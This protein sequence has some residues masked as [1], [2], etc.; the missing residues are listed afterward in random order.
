MLNRHEQPA[1]WPVNGRRR[2]PNACRQAL[3]TLLPAVVMMMAGLTAS[4]ENASATGEPATGSAEPVNVISL[5]PDRDGDRITGEWTLF[6]TP[7]TLDVEAA[8]QSIR[9]E[10]RTGSLDY[11]LT[12]SFY[13]LGAEMENPGGR[14]RWILEIKNPHIRYVELYV[15]PGDEATWTR[16]ER[17][18]HGTRFDSRSIRHNYYALPLAFNGPERMQ[19]LIMLDNV[20]ASINYPATVWREASFVEYQQRQYLLNG[21]Y[22]GG[23][24]L[25]IMA[26]AAAFLLFGNSLYWWFVLHVFLTGL[27]VFADLGYAFQYLYPWSDSLNIYIRIYLSLLWA[28]VFC[29]FSQRYF[30]TRVHAPVM[31]RLLHAGMIAAAATML[32]H[33][34]IEAFYRPLITPYLVLLFGVLLAVMLITLATGLS[35]HRKTYHASMLYLLAFSFL[36][37][38]GALTVI[39]EFGAMIELP[40]R[41]S[42]LQLG[43]GLQVLVLTFGITWIMKKRSDRQSAMKSRIGRLKAQTLQSHIQGMEEERRRIAMN[44]HDAIGNRMGRLKRMMDEKGTSTEAFREEISQLAREVRSISHELSPPGLQTAGLE[45]QVRNLVRET[46]EQSTVRYRL[47]CLDVPA[48][49]PKPAALQVYRVIQEAVNNIEKHSRASTADIQLIGYGDE[50]VITIEDDGVG[51]PEDEHN[52]E[53]MGLRNMRERIAHLGGT[54]ELASQPGRG[55]QCMMVIP[56]KG[57]P[58]EQMSKEAGKPVNP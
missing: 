8:W 56:L 36:L 11:G 26:S 21:L 1:G 33:P 39:E 42:T 10:G 24:I 51:L 45:Q 57:S 30:T 29:R 49:L 52:R 28:L 55:V 6:T 13:W 22:F 37:V 31:H 44:L 43:S 4:P 35:M 40:V 41:F 46:D 3:R 5:T 58:G 48:D 12:R 19:V 7:D 27:Y 17:T 34:P 16:V 14:D 25:V 18:G 2:Q 38:G 15:R 53:G 50:L 32:L 9:R 23:F 20:R 54:M 47:H